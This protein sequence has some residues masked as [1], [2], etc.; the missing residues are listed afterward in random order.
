MY[1]YGYV[2]FYLFAKYIVFEKTWQH[3]EY[4]TFCEY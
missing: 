2:P 1:P 3:V 4:K